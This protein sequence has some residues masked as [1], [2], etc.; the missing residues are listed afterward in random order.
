[1]IASFGHPGAI[2]SSSGYFH[3]PDDAYLLRD[4]TVTV[5]DAQNCRVLFLGPGPAHVADRNNRNLHPR[6][7]RAASARRTATRRWPTGTSSSPRSTARMSTS[8]LAAATSSGALI[9]QSPTRPI[10]SSSVRIATWSPIT[11]GP[12]GS[13]NS[14]A[15]G[16]ILWSYHPASGDG[17]LDHPSLAER[18]PGGLIAVTDDYR[19]RVALIDPHT[20][21]I[22]W[23]Y[24]RA[25]P[26]GHRTRSTEDSRRVRPSRPLGHHTDPSLHRLSWT[27]RCAGAPSASAARSGGARRR[28]WPRPPATPP[29][30]SAL[31]GHDDR[32]RDREAET[33]PPF[34][35]GTREV[36][37][38]EAVEDQ[39]PFARRD[40]RAVVVNGNPNPIAPPA[41]RDSHQTAGPR[42]LECVLDQVAQHLGEPVAVAHQT[43]PGDAADLHA[44]TGVRARP[45]PSRRRT[46][47]GRSNPCGRSCPR[48][49]GRA[50]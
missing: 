6:P 41:R 32:P 11:R 49:S 13:T 50:G 27:E 38:V 47:R 42:V 35:A 17:M 30:R 5:A 22:V 23:Q 15:A 48:R 31:M 26:S 1:M 7:A 9:F 33:A 3:E 21:R 46:A 19:D 8:S 34:P 29:P 40:S 12:A 37:S 24:G 36:S 25:E 20:K 44:R 18:F 4:G 2:G 10:L 45:P 14:I 39:L 28:S 43:T 16:R